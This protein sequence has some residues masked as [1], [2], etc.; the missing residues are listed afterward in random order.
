MVAALDTLRKCP[1]KAGHFFVKSGLTPDE[2]AADFVVHHAGVPATPRGGPEPAVLYPQDNT[3]DLL[4]GLYGCGSRIRS[5]LPGLADLTVPQAVSKLSP[6]SPTKAVSDHE[7]WEKVDLGRLPIP[8]ITDRDAGPY[9]TMGFILA[10]GDGQDLALSAHR[11]LVLGPDLLGVS[12]LTSRHL[13]HMAQDAWKQGKSLPISINIGV[14]P[15]VAVASAT[16]TAHLPLQFDKLSLAG[17]LAHEPIRLTEGGGSGAPYLS[18]SAFV[19]HGELLE[20]TSEETIEPAPAGVTMPEFLGY[21]GHAGAPLHLIKLNG[22]SQRPGAVFQAVVGPGREQSAILGL[23]GALSVALSVNDR[24]IFDLRFSYAG[25]GMLL[26]F[27]ALS[28]AD[29]VQLESLARRMIEISPFVKTVIFVDQ[30]VDLSSDEDIFWAMTTR[31][32][33]AQDCHPVEG[34]SP[35]RMDP[36]Q[37]LAWAEARGYAQTRCYVDATVP[38]ACRMATTRSFASR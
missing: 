17:A 20:E 32:N 31:A 22:I 6:I 26:L 37:G 27:V 16:G 2:A 1:A 12:M 8:K 23:G 4:L 11:M 28:D 29:G 7:H 38:A 30:D 18:Q 14:P 33:L 3:A 15:A 19:L 9:V 35:M 13:R 36:S 10:G 24:R 5:W 21:D 25:G 34:F